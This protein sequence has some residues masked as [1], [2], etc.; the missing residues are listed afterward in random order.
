MKIVLTLAVVLTAGI[1]AGA[2]RVVDIT[3]NDADVVGQQ[4]INGMVGGQVISPVTYVKVTEGTPYFSD[5]W[6]DGTVLLEG[7]K[8]IDHLKLR[9]DLVHKEI[10]YKDADGREMIATT[11]VRAVT[12]PGPAGNLV[13]IPGTPWRETDK[14]LD[15]AWLQVLVNDRVSL[16]YE[17]RKKMTENTPYGGSTVERTITDVSFYYLQINGKFLRIRGWSDVPAL[18]GDKVQAV[19]AFIRDNRLK[20]HTPDE[21]AKVVAYY[22]TLTDS[23]EVTKN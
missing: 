15:G 23:Q 18:L 8:A 13:F 17:V 21:Y 12:L 10:H 9:L 19:T 5:E 2:Q 11:P 1:P 4:M 16:L 20:G 7:G 6:L 22:N 14:A 3:H